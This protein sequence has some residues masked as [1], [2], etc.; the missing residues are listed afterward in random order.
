M[1]YLI[2]NGTEL[3]F[4]FLLMPHKH[5]FIGLLCY[6]L[7]LLFGKVDMLSGSFGTLSN[8][9]KDRLAPK[10]GSECVFELRLQVRLDWDLR[11]GPCSV[12]HD[13]F[14]KGLVV[15]DQEMCMI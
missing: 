10:L 7:A 9:S 13:L 11:E 5:L 3:T 1:N 12:C 8:C 15:C 6:P 2:C 4:E 14:N